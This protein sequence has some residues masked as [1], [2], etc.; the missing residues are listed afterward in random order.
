MSDLPASRPAPSAALRL[1]YLVSRYPAVSHTFILREVLA[2]RRLGATI[3]VASVNAPDR[4]LE[5]MTDD[6]RAEARATYCLKRDG[7]AGALLAA[8]HCARRH[9]LGCLR[10]FAQSV[11]LGRGLRRLYALAY[12]AEAMMV[13][14]WMARHDLQHLHVHFATAGANVGLLASTLAPI[15]LSLTVHGPDE[16]DDVRGQHL[17]RKLRAAD[18]VVCISQ[19]ARSQLMRLSDGT[20]WAKLQVCRL[21]VA[22]HGERRPA[23]G[24]TVPQLLCVGRLVPAK[25]QRVLLDACAQ[26]RAAGRAFRLTLVGHGDDERGLREHARGLG[27]DGCVTF[28]GAL[29]AGEVRAAL[30]RADVFVLPSLAEGIPVVL[31]EA[32]AAGVPCV[33]CPVNGIPELIEHGTNGLLATPGDANT[34]A[35][36]ITQLLDDPG[37]RERL[38]AA[39]RARVRDAFDLE[40]NAA[41]LAA[42]FSTLPRANGAASR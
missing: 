16:F 9:P 2:L 4:P 15:G 19:F 24:E 37:V 29:N 35:A 21:G 1:A 22:A 42:L 23:A 20:Q 5:R 33:S 3:E 32:M 40:R 17:A 26:L 38:A 11:T 36:R 6:E 13:V 27:L 25:G 14:R 31:M 39:G 10:A 30:E 7:I 12:L 8:L 41:R 34:L 18:L 28:A